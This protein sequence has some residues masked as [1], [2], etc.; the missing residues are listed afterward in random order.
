MY[1]PE[2]YLN[3][4][5]ALL[6][7]AEFEL[8]LKSFEEKRLYGIRINTL[9]ISVE[10]FQNKGLFTLEP[11]P[12]CKE[13]FYYTEQDRPSKHPYYHAGLYYIQEPSAMTTGALL[14]VQP[15]DRVLDICAAPG[16][17]STQL[18]AKLAG[19]GILIAND[20]SPS[21]TKALIKNIELFGICNAVIVSEAPESLAARFPAYF[22][23]IVIDAPCSGEGMFRKEPEVI[24]A[25]GEKMT[26][27]CIKE[28]KK[29]L[30]YAADM[31]CSGGE[32]IYSTCTFSP[33]E[34]E[35]AIQNFLDGHPD[36]S[37][38]PLPH[39]Y[40]FAEGRPDAIPNGREELKSCVR[41]FP[42]RVKGEGHFVSLLKKAGE[43]TAP[44]F[45]EVKGAPQKELES[46]IT[47]QK[48]NL[49]WEGKGIYQIF[50]ND[51]Y[52][53]PEGLPDLK[54]L[55]IARSGLY[56][57]QLK[58]NRFEPSQAFAMALRKE[59]VK[60]SVDFSMEDPDC[61]RYLKGDTLES[62][63]PNGWT[64]VLADGFPLGWAKRV[65]GRLKNKYLPGW[66]WE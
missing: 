4:M 1:L 30:D 32:I 66:K 20:I 17:K 40:G 33:C 3:T 63:G 18:G 64:L 39:E 37:L 26:A 49:I 7:E 51:L 43:E 35:Q 55:R 53:V 56:L 24:K 59:N 9:K 16:G 21:R 13:G 54:G 15:G 46:F 34:N 36:F 61:I 28:Q 10:E 48:E 29:I 11:V 5:K 45:A 25:W 60:Q 52:L 41:L 47:F 44:Y 31:L 62:E 58:K 14:P 2:Q 57:G 22:N 42:H 8:Y 12:W 23:K 19:E 27:F 6:S 65:N 38:V 50:G